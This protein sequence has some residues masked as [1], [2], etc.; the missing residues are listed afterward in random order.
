M[1]VESEARALYIAGT[2]VLYEFLTWLQE[3]E[4]NWKAAEPVHQEHELD[5]PHEVVKE[6]AAEAHLESYAARPSG[7][8]SDHVSGSS[9]PRSTRGYYLWSSLMAVLGCCIAKLLC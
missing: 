7:A 9:P 6:H 4:H 8:E 5:L 2:V 1:P 3:Q